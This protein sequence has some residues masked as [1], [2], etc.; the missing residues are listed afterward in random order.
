MRPPRQLIVIAMAL[1]LP[2]CAETAPE[3][4]GP[5]LETVLAA[6]PGNARSASADHAKAKETFEFLA[7]KGM[8]KGVV[9]F[10]TFLFGFFLAEFDPDVPGPPLR[11]CAFLGMGHNDWGRAN[12]DGGESLHKSV[13]DATAL[14]FPIA[15]DG[16]P[17]SGAGHYTMSF[18]G[19][20]QEVEGPDG[21]PIQVWV[22]RSAESVWGVAKVREEIGW[23]EDAEEPIFS[24]DTS[25]LQ[26]GW[27]YDAKGNQRRG[28]VHIR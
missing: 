22:P 24:E 14:V 11:V 23:D 21:E 9:F 3:V 2:A 26:C 15:G 4:T 10:D 8:S 5:E 20:S 16:S 18:S 28:G 25:T 12:P 19:S 13:K 27:V 17:Y 1:A 6:A 7:S